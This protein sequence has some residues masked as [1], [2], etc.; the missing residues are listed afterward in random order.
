MTFVPSADVEAIRGRLDHPVIDSDG[1]LIEYLPLVRDFLVEEAGESV[2]Q[3][4]RPD[5]EVGAAR[6][7]RCPT[8]RSDDS[9]ASTPPASGASR[10]GT[11]STGRR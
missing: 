6:A 1:H 10:R 5:D 2:A 3:A 8:R 7:S 4:V 9:S 11:R